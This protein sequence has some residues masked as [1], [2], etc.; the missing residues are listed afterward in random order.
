MICPNCKTRWADF[1]PEDFLFTRKGIEPKHNDAEAKRREA[2]DSDEKALCLNC[3]DE[4][5][6]IG[7]YEPCWER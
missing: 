2:Y 1:P 4:V 5:E 6:L 3:Q 7:R